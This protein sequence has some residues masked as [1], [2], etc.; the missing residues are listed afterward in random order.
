[1]YPQALAPEAS[2]SAGRDA[3]ASAS[4]L[5]PAPPPGSYRGLLCSYLLLSSSL[6][7]SQVLLAHQH[8]HL[9]H[10]PRL[11]PPTRPP[12]QTYVMSQLV[13]HR[14]LW[15]VFKGAQ[16]TLLARVRIHTLGCAEGAR[17]ESQ[18]QGHHTQS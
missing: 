10:P 11:L 13:L 5:P 2:R 1:M 4:A 3:A 15:P 8:L 9:Q 12:T 17:S 14:A 18:R 6:A 7:A 16:R